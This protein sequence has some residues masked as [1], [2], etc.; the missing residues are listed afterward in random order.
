MGGIITFYWATSSVKSLWSL[1]SLGF[2]DEAI[3]FLAVHH[4][5][6]GD[7]ALCEL[8]PQLSAGQAPDCIVC[9]G[10][11][12]S[13]RFWQLSSPPVSTISGPYT[14]HSYRELSPLAVSPVLSFP[15]GRRPP[16]GPCPT[17][18]SLAVCTND[19]PQC[20]CIFSRTFL[21]FLCTACSLSPLIPVP[22]P[23][24]AVLVF[25]L[26]RVCRCSFQDPRHIL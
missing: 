3:C 25:S 14:F 13:P 9:Y 12:H 6:P 19:I 5:I 8:P 2:I 26:H 1:I 10:S 17:W 22:P 11:L 15:R 18:T 16:R 23:A 21:T 4:P 24:W 20:Q 7:T